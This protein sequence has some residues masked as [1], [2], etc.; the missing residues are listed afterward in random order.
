MSN[1][2]KSR[3]HHWWP[4]GLQKYWTDKHG[5]LWWIEPDGKLDKKRA[6]N[7][8][9]AYKS[10]GHTVLRGTDF[11]SNFEGVFQSA[12]DGVPNVIKALLK[13]KP[14]GRTPAEFLKVLKLLLK[15]DR[16]LKDI[17]NY[18]DLEEDIQRQLL[19]ILFSL[20]IRSPGNRFRYEGFPE[21]IGLP[22]DEEVGKMNMSQQ[23]RIAKKLCE[24]GYLTN[25]YFVF[26][27]S[28]LKKFL[29]GD[30]NLDWLTS[31]LV[32]NRIDGRALVPLTPHLCVYLC[33]PRAMMASPNCASLNAAPWMVDWI[34]HI[35]QIYSR[36]K[37]FFHG[38][39][40][41]LSEEFKQRQFLEHTR[42]TDEL[43]D[44]LDD[45][46]GIEKPSW[47]PGIGL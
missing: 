8:K 10:H 43:V 44:M 17:C 20:L 26:I 33:T 23:Y 3:E 4:V 6:K 40:P 25:Q 11:E 41:Q 38:K 31:S 1:R 34:N 21:M 12:D 46:A 29:F 42:K 27:H 37:L 36:D 45:I 28:P 24:D 13:L 5:D 47:F 18:Y 35:V 15:K 14:F 9:I 30:G 7:R 19:L 22:R 16:S 39:P 2:S 32:G